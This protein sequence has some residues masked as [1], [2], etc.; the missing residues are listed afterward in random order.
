MAKI[1]DRIVEANENSK[2][3]SK[4]QNINVR[5]GQGLEFPRF[6][7][8]LESAMKIN[9]LLVEGG[10]FLNITLERVLTK[11]G[12]TVVIAQDGEQGLRIAC[13]TI[14][15]LILLDT[16]LPKMG[17]QEV[18]RALK[19]DPLTADIPV[20]ILSSLS[21]QN[22]EKFKKNGAAAYFEKAK[23]IEDANSGKLHDAISNAVLE[24]KLLKRK[25][26]FVSR[27]A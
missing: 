11:A 14:P 6:N 3:H 9:V 24:S 23:L 10:K 16:L 21:Q 15:D 5:T 19:N 22:E 13:Q 7:H 17:G 8:R 18:L 20:I 4:P 1:V 25:S 27:N 2:S 26:L 12:F